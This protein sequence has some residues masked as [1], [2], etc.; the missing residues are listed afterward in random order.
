M[1]EALLVD[2]RRVVENRGGTAVIVLSD[3][4]SR[5]A[6]DEVAV[7]ARAALPPSLMRFWSMHDGLEVRVYG[8][9]EVEGV[10]THQLV[11]RGIG[12]A[13]AASEDLRKFFA[14]VRE[15]GV[16]WY[17]DDAAARYLDVADKDDPNLHVL[18]DLGRRARSG[19]CPLIEV[20]L[21]DSDWPRNPPDPIADSLDEFVER[22]LRFMI[23][24]Q[25]GF[26]YWAPPDT[27]W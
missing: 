26:Q 22:S 1:L 6:I 21:Y 12:S 23:E 9:E 8:A 10:T 19:E 24:T 11:V 14:G 13:I 27:D 15:S 4:A 20:G 3:S 18:T 16:D 7:F 5:A 17:T 25:G 2:V